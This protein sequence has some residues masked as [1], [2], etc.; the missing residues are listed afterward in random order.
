MKSLLKQLDSTYRKEN[1]YAI[2]NLEMQI[3]EI[4]KLL[5]TVN[6]IYIL[7]SIIVE[8]PTLI[9]LRVEILMNI[10]PRLTSSLFCASNA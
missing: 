4:L 6:G 5:I 1:D 10:L 3:K 9:Y 2:L 7:Y 8:L